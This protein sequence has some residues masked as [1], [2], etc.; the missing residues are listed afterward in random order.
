MAT[1]TK[2][3]RPTILHCR[4]GCLPAVPWLSV[5]RPQVPRVLEIFADGFHSVV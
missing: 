3:A 4:N 2:E 5:S 1:V